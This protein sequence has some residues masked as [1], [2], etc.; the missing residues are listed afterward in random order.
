M[1]NE[2]NP[3][4]SKP[5]TADLQKAA[6]VRTITSAINVMP[7]VDVDKIAEVYIKNN[8]IT[9]E[10]VKNLKLKHKVH[11]VV[12]LPLADMLD[13]I[14]KVRE[15]SRAPI[16]DFWTRMKMVTAEDL[17]EVESQFPRLRMLAAKSALREPTLAELG[18][19]FEGSLKP[20]VDAGYKTATKEQY[21]DVSAACGNCK[22][23]AWDSAGRN[24]LGK[25]AKA[26]YCCSSTFRRW[27]ADAKCPAGYWPK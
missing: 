10:E 1:P 4:S 5:S 7:D 16:Y 8:H 26:K 21:V 18:K 25:C 12:Q 3:S 11:P 15:S 9:V 13:E 23:K 6:A 20:W 2:N 27:M 17:K 14:S 19:D 22:D 24:G